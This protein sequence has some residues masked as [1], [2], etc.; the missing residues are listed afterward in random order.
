MINIAKRQILPA[1]AEYSGKLAATVASISSTG[2]CSDYQ[3]EMLETVSMLIGSAGKALK[4]LEAVVEKCAKIEDVSNKAE[5]C[6]DKVIPA[7]CDLRQFADELEMNVDADLWPLPT[8][9]E[10]LFLK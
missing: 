2:L 7:M 9:A 1:S 6:R 5:F 4:G 3:K 10:M 8:Y